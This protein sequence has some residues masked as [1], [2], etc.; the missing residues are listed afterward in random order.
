MFK[1]KLNVS[2]Y[3]IVKKLKWLLE[4]LDFLIFS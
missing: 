4:K 1:L 3:K 2:M